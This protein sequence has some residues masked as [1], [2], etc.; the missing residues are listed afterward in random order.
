MS[1][2]MEHLILHYGEQAESLKVVTVSGYVT[3]WLV[4]AL[5]PEGFQIKNGISG[6]W[7]CKFQTAI[8]PHSQVVKKIMQSLH[9]NIQI[10]C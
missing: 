10:F 6:G 4:R 9:A 5:Q 2:D 1:W 3:C 8:F 7:K